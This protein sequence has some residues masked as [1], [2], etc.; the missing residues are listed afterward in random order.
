MMTG[1]HDVKR[2]RA[3]DSSRRR[4]Q[5]QDRRARILATAEH[6]FLRDG[7]A[8]TTVAGLAAAADVSPETVFKTFGGKAGLVRAIQQAAL[9]GTGPAPAPDRSDAMSAREDDPEVIIRR[10]ASL[11]EE[12]APRVS[13]IAL[14]VRTAAATHPEMAELLDAIQAQRLERMAHNARRLFRVGGL[15]ADATPEHARDVLFTYTSPELYETLILTLGW[16]LPA[17]SDF[18]YRGIRAQLLP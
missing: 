4:L 3:Y 5:A 14:L 17:Y 13:P 18:I 10:W 8:A 6:L 7:Y 12:V 1:P 9:G 11:S 15:R 2:P 16:S